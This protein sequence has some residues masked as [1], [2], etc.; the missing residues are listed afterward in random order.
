MK[1]K[2]SLKAIALTLALTATCATTL[3]AQ[4][5]QEPQEKEQRGGVIGKIFGQDSK[6]K[7]NDQKKNASSKSSTQA[8]ERL[9]PDDT[10]NLPPGVSAEAQ[11]G[12]REQA[13]ED[14]AAIL[15]YYNNFLTSYHIGPEDVIS[16]DVFNQPRYSKANITVPPNGKISYPLIPEG[17]IVV[18][19]TTEQIQDEITKRLDEYIIDPQV[20]VSLDKAV[21]A[22]YSVIGDVGQPG[23]RT[24]THRY[25]VME[26]LAMAGGV[27]ETGDKSKVVI[28]RQ[29]ADGNVK[30]IFVNVKKIE[31]GQ[32]KEMAFLVPGD[33]VVVPG[34]KFKILDKVMKLIPVLSFARIFT[35][36][37]W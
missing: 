12:R 13:S 27:L 23:V 26:A 5:T 17:V 24:M 29:Q 30:P 15:P 28:L 18:G 32:A 36:G 22:T 14:E 21:S 11:A 9:E 10:N 2:N 4:A 35:G 34:N 7:K 20:Q 33:Q 37:G 8:S 31:R 6:T 3:L 19:K 16:V 1:M 25:S